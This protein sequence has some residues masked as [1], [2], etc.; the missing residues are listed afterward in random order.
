[1]AACS[2]LQDL[3]NRGLGEGDN[4]DKLGSGDSKEGDKKKKSVQI[5]FTLGKQRA[6]KA[7]NHKG[8]CPGAQAKS[9]LSLGYT[10]K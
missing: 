9:V 2:D 8:I 3:N 7:T 6:Y 10:L 4:N 1:M 5:S